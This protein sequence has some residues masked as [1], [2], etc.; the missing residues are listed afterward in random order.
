[1]VGLSLVLIPESLGFWPSIHWPRRLLLF[2]LSINL[3]FCT[4]IKWRR[5]TTSVLMIHGGIVA[6]LVGGALGSLG[7]VATVNIH[8]GSD[9]ATA[10]RWDRQ[11]DT[12]LGFRLM[13]KRINYDYYPTPVRIGVLVDGDPV[14]L[15]EFITGESL[16]CAGLQIEALGFDP[17]LPALTLAVTFP[18]GRRSEIMAST[19]VDDVKIGAVIQLVAFKTPVVKRTWIDMAIIVDGAPP[20]NGQSEV[21]RPLIW[22]GLRFFHTATGTDPAGQSY[23]GIQIVKDRGLP[24]VYLG[25]ALLLIGNISFFINKMFDHRRGCNSN[26][27]AE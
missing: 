9:T 26:R 11:E 24:L 16:V 21:N 12:P 13:V 8:E 14:Q 18:D 27:A 7:F 3:I 19:T 2:A 1:M 5:L 10:F 4:V 15:C 6:I 22:Q 20:F 25:F 23:A 17:T